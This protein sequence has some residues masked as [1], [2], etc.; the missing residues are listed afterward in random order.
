M[1]RAA[2]LSALAG[3]I[4]LLWP[5]S[6]GA[7]DA[8]GG[9]DLARE[10]LQG[11]LAEP[12]RAGV[13]KLA[14]TVGATSYSEARVRRELEHR[15]A[16]VVV[17][18][19][20]RP[21]EAQ[22]T[23]SSVTAFAGWDLPGASAGDLE[24]SEGATRIA[25]VEVAS[26]QTITP[27][28]VE[29]TRSCLVEA[30]VKNARAIFELYETLHS[31]DYGILISA[32]RREVAVFTFDPDRYDIELHLELSVPLAGLAPDTAHEGSSRLILR[33][34]GSRYDNEPGPGVP[35][36]T[37][38]RADL[39]AGLEG[40]ASMRFQHDSIEPVVERLSLSASACLPGPP[41]LSDTGG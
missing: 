24:Y 3:A 34:A 9:H 31:A 39:L 22:R 20:T 6:G 12:D 4:A 27:W 19:L 23:E 14:T 36:V 13:T 33:D 1:R 10:L 35:T 18:D 28:R 30:P 15:E 21:N 2:V 29:R 41:V 26:G 40:P 38:T 7:A 5:V 11:C 37:L 8:P 25:R 17:D 32:D 16:S